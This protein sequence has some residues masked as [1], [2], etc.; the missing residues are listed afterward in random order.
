MKTSNPLH[1][2]RAIVIWLA[3]LAILA[4]SFAAAGL[5]EPVPPKC[6]VLIGIDNYNSGA[7]SNLKFCK[8]DVKLFNDALLQRGFKKDHIIILT[9]DAE[10][11]SLKPTK[12]NILKVLEN[13]N[14]ISN[15]EMV[16][17]YFSG[18]AWTP[19]DVPMLIPMN[20]EHERPTETGLTVRD[21]VDSLKECEAD[22]R[23][24]LID[25]HPFP[26]DVENK[27]E[28]LVLPPRTALLCAAKPGFMAY[29]SR[30]HKNGVFTRHLVDG[31]LGEADR[32]GDSNGEV[33]LAELYLY[34]KSQ[35]AENKEFGR[36][37]VPG[38]IVSNDIDDLFN[39]TIVKELP[40]ESELTNPESPNR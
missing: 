28:Q 13:L 37:L 4:P 3:F 29:E 15:A 34:V 40:D 12:E 17:V 2:F 32:Q 26:R 5:G 16:I 8:A 11:V 19:D 30:E 39:L 14:N 1:T 21:L 23:L 10:D 33:D 27:K 6:A 24:F 18:H 7:V 25:S 22:S 9:D 36:R 35:M 20:F 38:L 31:L